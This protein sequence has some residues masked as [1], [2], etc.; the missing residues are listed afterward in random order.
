MSAHHSILPGNQPE[1]G[2]Q[3]VHVQTDLNLKK[4]NSTLM[5]LL[6][7]PSHMASASAGGPSL[8]Q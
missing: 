8:V 3:L 4:F 1:L 5:D 7:R 6:S 2:E